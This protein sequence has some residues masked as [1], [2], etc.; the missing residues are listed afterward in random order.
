MIFP[1]KL[2]GKFNS[3][4]NFSLGTD[5]LIIALFDRHLSSVL[6]I[7]KVTYHLH[8]LEIQATFC[9]FSWRDAPRRGT[10]NVYGYSRF[11]TEAFFKSLV[12][13]KNT[14]DT[15]KFF[16]DICKR[17]FEQIAEKRQSC[18][19]TFQFSRKLI[20]LFILIYWK[21]LWLVEICKSHLVRLS[22]GSRKKRANFPYWNIHYC[23]YED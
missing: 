20:T 8:N 17:T 15:K 16:A 19:K 1:S 9:L 22:A 13:W 12:F 3:R 2:T 23:W 21:T 5:Y 18:K 7:W 4:F 10:C 14:W 6:L 11:Y